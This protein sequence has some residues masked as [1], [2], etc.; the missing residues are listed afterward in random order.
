L[1]FFLKNLYQESLD[2]AQDSQR[3][4]EQ[5]ESKFASHLQSS[6]A[7]SDFARSRSMREQREFL[8]VFGVREE[9]LKVVR[10][11]QGKCVLKRNKKKN[12]LI[13]IRCNVMYLFFLSCHYC[14]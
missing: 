7:V 9:L 10:D 4:E 6:H 8:P 2:Q 14:R 3:Q 5:G 1:Y 13:N 11:N 12:F